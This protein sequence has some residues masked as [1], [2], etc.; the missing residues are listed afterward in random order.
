MLDVRAEIAR[1]LRDIIEPLIAA[2][3]GKLYLVTS[4]PDTVALHLAGRYSGCPGI[5]LTTRRIIEPALAAVAPS[6][7]VTVTSGALVPA[8]AEL[9]RKDAPGKPAESAEETPISSSV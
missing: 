5:T 8:G 6:V 7:R 9:V 3:G 2:D 4:D 1:V